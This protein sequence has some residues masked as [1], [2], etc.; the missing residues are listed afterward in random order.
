MGKNALTLY[1]DDVTETTDPLFAYK[2]AWNEVQKELK[3]CGVDN[4]KDWAG[5]EF[6]WS[7]SDANKPLGCCYEKQDGTS[8][9]E[10]QQNTCDELSRIQIAQITTSEDVTA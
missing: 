3:C 10:E 6:Q 1:K 8:M 5:D 4:V 2:S 9:D 7:P